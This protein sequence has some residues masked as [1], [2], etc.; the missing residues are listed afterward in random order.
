LRNCGINARMLLKW[1]INKWDM[2]TYIRLKR[3]R[4]WASGCNGTDN[5][6][7]Y[8]GSKLKMPGTN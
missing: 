6:K 4:V 3:L 2:K 5:G 1:F 8:S 7:S